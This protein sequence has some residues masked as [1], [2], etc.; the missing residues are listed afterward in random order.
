MGWVVGA[1]AGALLICLIALASLVR[2]VNELSPLPT[3]LLLPVTVEV[4]ELGF[5]PGVI[6]VQPGAEVRW[7]FREGRHSLADVA[8]TWESGPQEGGVF[9]RTMPTAGETISFL[10][11]ECRFHGRRG[12]IHLLPEP[13][14]ASNGGV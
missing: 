3:V 7:A 14:R 1:L 11:Y 6:I 12:S 4:T 8:G 2:K 9:S 10:D 5:R 13:I